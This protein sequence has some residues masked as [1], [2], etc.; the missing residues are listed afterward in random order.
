MADETRL[1][2]QEIERQSFAIIKK[3]VRLREF[4]ADVHPVL[5]RVVHATGDFQMARG[6]D[7]ACDLRLEGLHSLSLIGLAHPALSARWGRPFL[8]TFDRA[9]NTVPEAPLHTG[10]AQTAWGRKHVP[11]PR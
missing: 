11:S 6:S 9:A 1:A 2:P 10:I 7:Q 3:H 8:M 5:L 4:P